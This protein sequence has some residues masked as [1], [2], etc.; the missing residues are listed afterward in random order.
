MSARDLFE[1]RNVAADDE[2]L[3][4]ALRELVAGGFRVMLDIDAS[5]ASARLGGAIGVTS[6]HCAPDILLAI[7]AAASEAKL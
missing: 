2:A 3:G 4:R 1:G 7:K 5:G 6:E